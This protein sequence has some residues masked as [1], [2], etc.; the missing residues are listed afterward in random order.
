MWSHPF[1]IRALCAYMSSGAARSTTTASTLP[2][3]TCSRPSSWVWRSRHRS[4]RRFPSCCSSGR[5]VV[6]WVVVL[7]AVFICEL[8]HGV[9]IF[10]ELLGYK[11]ECDTQTEARVSVVAGCLRGR[12]PPCTI[13]AGLTTGRVTPHDSLCPHPISLVSNVFGSIPRF[14]ALD[15]LPPGLFIC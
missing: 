14:T 1:S 10:Y 11:Q 2:R 7:K 12:L 15:L 5:P 6:T 9:R 4:T 8:K 13:S 3:S